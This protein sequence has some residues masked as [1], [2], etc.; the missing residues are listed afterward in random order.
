MLIYDFIIRIVLAMMLGLLIGLERQL[1]GHMAGIR[2]NVLLCM[3]TCFFTLFP[4]WMLIVS[5]VL[6][7]PLA[8]KIIP[9]T[10]NEESENQYCITVLCQADA[11]NDIRS[12]LINTNDCITSNRYIRWKAIWMKL[13]GTNEWLGL[14][15]GFWVYMAIVILIVIG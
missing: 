14:N 3:G 2:I 6:F 9:I 15:M 1:T 10:R 11:E 12:L 13:F 8:Q 5:N 7:Q 4:L